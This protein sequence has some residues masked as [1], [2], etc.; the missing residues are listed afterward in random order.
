MTLSNL[1]DPQTKEVMALFQFFD[2]DRDGL[3]SPRSASKLCSQLGFH[4]EPAHF[5][6]DPGST[7]LSLPDLLNWVDNF[8][9]Q[10]QRSKELSLAQ[11]FALL[12]ACDV[13]A[14]GPRV[15]REALMHF[16]TLEKHTVGPEAI[17][18]LLEEVGT[19]GQLSKSDLAAVLRMGRRTQP[20]AT[21]SEPST[22]G[23]ALRKQTS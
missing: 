22:P 8:I 19:D 11:R 23:S 14:S 1:S 9:G 17:D 4:L 15:S 10:C 21:G 2:T 20:R 16:L 12:R 7:P 3:V 5:A 18:E 6:G 13:H